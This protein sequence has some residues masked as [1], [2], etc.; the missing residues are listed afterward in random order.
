MSKR[1]LTAY[2][3]QSR[4]YV[5]RLMNEYY[6][7]EFEKR[8]PIYSRAEYLRLMMENIERVLGKELEGEERRHGAITE[9][10]KREIKSG[11]SDE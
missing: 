8:N 2:E 5:L 3:K 6:H 9:R 1:K 11:E 7:P 4:R 10:L